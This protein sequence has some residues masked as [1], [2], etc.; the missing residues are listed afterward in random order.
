M[1]AEVESPHNKNNPFL[2]KLTENRLL[3][4]DGSIKDTRHLVVNISGSGLNYTCG[5]SLGVYPTNR[6]ENVAELLEVLGADGSENVTL[7]REEQAITLQEALSQRLS[8]ASPAKKFLLAIQEKLEAGE[9]L[10]RLE[11]LLEPEN[12]EAMT[13]Y[14]ANREFV[15]VLEDFPSAK[16]EPQEFVLQ[17]RKLVPRLYSIASSPVPYPEDIHLTVAV[18]RYNTNGRERHG[19]C[20]TFLAERATL[21]EAVVPVF[22]TKSHFGLPEDESTDIIMVGPG[23]GIAPFRSFLQER[24]AKGSSGRNWLFFGDQHEASDFLYQEELE[25]YEKDGVLTRFD[26]AWSRD[27]EKK[28]YVQDRMLE[29]SAELWKWLQGGASFFVCGDAKRMAKDVDAALHTIAQEQG[30]LS[31]EEAKNY[32]KLLKKEKRYLRDVY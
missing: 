10:S 32:F 4:K 15:D 18:V 17:L 20:S 29:N 2:A 12:K 26:K 25:A 21:N 23:T 3:N 27:Q 7:P 9:E 13:D 11:S 14:L 5:D 24:A 28:V 22:V 1:A 8:L 30:G 31:E 6:A 16:F 19:V